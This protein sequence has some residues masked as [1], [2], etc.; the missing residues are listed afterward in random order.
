[1]TWGN[2]SVIYAVKHEGGP[3]FPMTKNFA[4]LKAATAS[5]ALIFFHGSIGYAQDGF[6]EWQGTS[7]GDFQVVTALHSEGTTYALIVRDAQGRDFMCR[8][9]GSRSFGGI[10]EL[11]SCEPIIT[12]ENA[13]RQDER[14]RI[15]IS[16]FIS[17]N[18]PRDVCGR[19]I[20]SLYDMA[21]ERFEGSRFEE[22][23]G[24]WN[25]NLNNRLIR[26]ALEAISDLIF[27]EARMREGRVWVD[28][29]VIWSEFEG[30][31]DTI[32]FEQEG[33]RVLLEGACR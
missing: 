13:D 32:T 27:V 9:Y 23:F 12:R 33:R 17:E 6:P 2:R 26:E 5:L 8:L 4:N 31:L 24:R 10:Q 18:V 22:E 29:R 21:Y 28:G 15:L 20:S 1:M 3:R 11:T 14:N 30:E 25:R 7:D 19:D 16:N